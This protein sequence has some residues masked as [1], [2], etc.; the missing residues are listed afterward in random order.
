MNPIGMQLVPVTTLCETRKPKA[1]TRSQDCGSRREEA[2]IFLM[3]EL[4]D[5]GCYAAL[6][7]LCRL[8]V[9]N[10][11][12]ATPLREQLDVDGHACAPW[13]DIMQTVLLHLIRIFKVGDGRSSVR[14]GT[15][16]I[17]HPTAL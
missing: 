5:I 13:L 6:P 1:G 8:A 14:S 9:S 3:F 12:D 2:L 11:P 15:N 17:L 7:A 10:E 16:G 4:R